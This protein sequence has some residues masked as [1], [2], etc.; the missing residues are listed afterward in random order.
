MP[1]SVVGHA[2]PR[3]KRLFAKDARSKHFSQPG[4]ARFARSRTAGWP[5][6]SLLTLFFLI[7]VCSNLVVDMA[8][9]GYRLTFE[10]EAV[11]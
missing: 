7:V 1:S 3:T 2:L 6:V 9:W 8:D 4:E 11:P 10:S 5:V